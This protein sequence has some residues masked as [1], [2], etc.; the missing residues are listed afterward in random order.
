MFFFK[1]TIIA[2]YVIFFALV[3]YSI[4]ASH[5]SS[6]SRKKICSCCF[7]VCVEHL[8]VSLESVKR[9]FC[10]GRRSGKSLEFWMQKSL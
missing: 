8:F 5:V 7:E 9:M 10:F 6:A 3:K 4:S 1:A 2:I